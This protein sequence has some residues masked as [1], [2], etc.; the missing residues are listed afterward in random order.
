MN[1]SF[2]LLRIMRNAAAGIA[3][4]VMALAS[5]PASAQE[6]VTFAWPV[7][8]NSGLAPFIFAQELGFFKEENV[9]VS[10]THLDVYKRQ[11]VASPSSFV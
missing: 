10:Y 7:A 11:S 1:S 4:L 8:I 5:Q 2:S 9:A 6:K 3:A